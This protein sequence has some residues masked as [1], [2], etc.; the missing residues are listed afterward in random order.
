MF[1]LGCQNP[2]SSPRLQNPPLT[3]YLPPFCR[4]SF[5]GQ[6]EPRRYPLERARQRSRRRLD[7]GPPS[8]SGVTVQSVQIVPVSWSFEIN[9]LE[10]V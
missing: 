4:G 10:M 3:R 6:G 9:Y 5:L 8:G 1:V 7:A 2:T